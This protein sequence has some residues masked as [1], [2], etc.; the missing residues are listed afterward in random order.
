MTTAL[1]HWYS[2]FLRRRRTLKHFGRHP[3]ANSVAG[4]GPT[5]APAEDLARDLLRAAREDPAAAPLNQLPSLQHGNLISGVA[6]EQGLVLFVLLGSDRPTGQPPAQQ[7][8]RL[9][10][11][12]LGTRSV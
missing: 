4:R 1:T 9:V 6:V 7:L 12:R 10:L 11:R 5:P 8:E 3:L 2:G